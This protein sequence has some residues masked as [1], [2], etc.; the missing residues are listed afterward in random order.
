MSIGLDFVGAANQY[1][2]VLRYFR[3][4]KERPPFDDRSA[5][6]DA[7]YSADPVATGPPPGV[8]T[9]TLPLPESKPKIGSNIDRSFGSR[10]DIFHRNTPL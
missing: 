9:N 6:S 10:G 3:H 1:L 7:T 5:H 8:G 4:K 2:V